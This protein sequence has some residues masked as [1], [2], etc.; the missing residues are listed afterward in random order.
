[1]TKLELI[2]NLSIRFSH[3][4]NKDV[5]AAVYTTFEKPVTV[6]K[7]VGLAAFLCIIANH[8]KGVIPRPVSR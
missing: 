8:A 7:F 2:E 6:W 1:M 3:L 5:K 4:K